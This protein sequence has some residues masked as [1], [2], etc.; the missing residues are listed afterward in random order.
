VRIGRKGR[1]KRKKPAL[2]QFP[3]LI[4]GVLYATFSH[5]KPGTGA[6]WPVWVW[7]AL[8]PDVSR[9]GT[10]QGFYFPFLVF[11]LRTFLLL[12]GVSRRATNDASCNAYS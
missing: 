11:V 2:D 12:F 7:S 9:I 5:H 1:K 6:E 4:T 8:A 3:R 10:V